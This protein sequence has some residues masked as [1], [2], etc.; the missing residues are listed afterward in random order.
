MIWYQTGTIS[1]SNGS[2]IVTAV[3]AAFINNVAPGAGFITADGRVYPVAEVNSDNQLTL[4]VPY[5]GATIAGAAYYILPTQAYDLM[6]AR[7]IMTLTD[8]FA[9][10]R[11]GV[12]NGL[13]PAGTVAAPGIRF[14][15]DQ[16]TGVWSPGNNL[17]S[18]VTGGLEKLRVGGG[19]AVLYDSYYITMG[20][21]ARAPVGLIGRVA[22]ANSWLV[23]GDSLVNGVGA[24]DEGLSLYTY[25]GAPIRLYTSNG[26]AMRLDSSRNLLV[27][28]NSGN[29][30]T[31]QKGSSQGDG[32]LNVYASAL[33]FAGSGAFGSGAATAISVC[34]NTTTGRSINAG[35]T[36]NAS[37][38]DYAEYMLKATN[39]GLIAKADVCGVD[40]DGNLT[41]SWAAAISFVVKSTDP[42]YV[43][44]DAWAADLGEKPTEPGPAPLEPS[45]PAMPEAFAAAPV[46]PDRAEGES[47]A[48]FDARMESFGA[49]TIAHAENV[50]ALARYH[51]AA[52]AYP[53]LVAAYQVALA[54]H[55]AAVAQYES[56]LPAWE[57]ELEAL[58]TRVDRIAFSGQVPCNVTGDF[59]VGDY[60]VAAPNGGGIKA[61][62]VPEADM[63]LPLYM[64]RIGKVWA[65]TD[66]GRAWIDVQHG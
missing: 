61:I 17:I 50:I 13:F 64:K 45:A 39:C 47:D 4:A 10:V 21:T 22:G 33:F 40:A 52:A 2:P 43:G 58:R 42:A 63:T 41:K 66:D 36:I 56:E 60:I 65:V 6:L 46:L 53:G 15:N 57:A 31:I 30:H 37:G 12:G 48:E 7:R 35:G 3:G 28:V 44:G 38:A 59:A 23:G 29:T 25:G 27:G 5:Q 26:E 49:A 8:N 20:S 32:Q 51:E 54:K 16:D 34:T 55:D 24:L 1:V 14:S 9:D 18:L 11:D 62:A 19:E